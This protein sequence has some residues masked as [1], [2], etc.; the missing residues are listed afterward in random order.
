MPQSVKWQTQKFRRPNLGLGTLQSVDLSLPPSNLSQ[1]VLAYPSSS[2][3]WNFVRPKLGLTNLC[4]DGKFQASHSHGSQGAKTCRSSGGKLVSDAQWPWEKSF[5]F[6]VLLG[7]SRGALPP[8]TGEKKKGAGIH[9]ASALLGAP[10]GEVAGELRPNRRTREVEGLWDFAMA[11]SGRLK[12]KWSFPAC[13]V[14]VGFGE[15]NVFK[16]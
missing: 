9:W 8:T 12:S 2:S 3:A 6:F 16:F 15:Q 7:L 13:L 5:V 14:D 4:G 1:N 10:K 11:T